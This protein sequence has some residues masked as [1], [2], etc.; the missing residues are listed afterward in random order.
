MSVN[1]L[2]VD[3]ADT[4]LAAHPSVIWIDVFMLDTNG[5]ARGKRCR[6]E[7]LGG[8]AKGGISMPSSI[9]V[10]G[11]RGNC[12]EETG[13][14]WEVGDPDIRYRVIA[15][16]LKLSGI[17]GCTHAQAVLAVDGTERQDPAFVLNKEVVKL[18]QL[19]YQACV[20]VELEFYLTTATPDGRFELQTPKGLAS[21]PD[22]SMT[23][24]FEE[25]DTIN[26]FINDVYRVAAVQDV[27]VDAIIQEAGPGQFEINLKHRTDP[28]A[29]ALDGLLL[30]RIIKLVAKTHGMDATFMPKPHHDWSGSGMHVHTSL[31][32]ADSRNVFAGKPISDI[33][34]FAIG[35]LQS[36]MG[37]CMAIWSQSGNAYKRYV[38]K[39]YVSTAAHWGFNNR[40]VALRIPESDPAAT[41]IE[42]RVS[43]ADANPYLVIACI[44]AGIESGI[45][46][47]TQ[48]GQMVDGNAGGVSSPALPIR[49]G[50][51]LQLFRE[52]DFIRNAF[53]SEF[54]H[55]YFHLKES[56][57]ASF[58]RI[59][60]A[61]DHEWYAKLS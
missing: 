48:P 37:D 47:R 33:C 42:H 40:M 50:E 61:H 29:A 18:K 39:S 32:D 53:G 54:Q 7:D 16:T 13:R 9:F 57:R 46:N 51:A 23:Y 59:V 2:T 10:I 36:T 44:L 30:K 3:E 22:F 20:A 11:V 38:S 25:L 5:I 6:R 55:G 27:P 12:V 1:F 45:R 58:E 14:L 17:D 8:V 49:W 15:G 24:Q 4:F 56:D 60:T 52:S 28:S 34:R 21:N 26:A 41:R 43:G 35:G 19:G 31:L